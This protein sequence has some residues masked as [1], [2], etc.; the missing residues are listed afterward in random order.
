[1]KR[2]LLVFGGLAVLGVGAW[3]VYTVGPESMGGPM[4]VDVGD[5]TL[6]RLDTVSLQRRV[7]TASVTGRVMELPSDRD[8]LLSDGEGTMQVRL[9]RDHE[10]R[11]GETLLAVGRLREVRGEPRRLE[12]R[13]WSAIQRAIV[14]LQTGLDSVRLAP[15][16]TRLGD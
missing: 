12:A 5:L 7:V 6:A 14:P 3:A 2:V 15:D 16:A 11:I 1:M 4:R 9:G 8:L 13:S 10:V